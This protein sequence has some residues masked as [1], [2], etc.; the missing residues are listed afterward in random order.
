MGAGGGGDRETN[1]IFFLHIQ[2]FA[3]IRIKNY[4]MFA[5][6]REDSKGT[7]GARFTTGSGKHC[8]WQD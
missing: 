4:K 1:Q 6:M 3:A 7:T 8:L 5:S 2:A